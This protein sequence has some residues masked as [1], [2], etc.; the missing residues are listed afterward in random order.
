MKLAILLLAATITF[1]MSAGAVL[2]K[3]TQEQL[4]EKARLVAVKMDQMRQKDDDEYRRL[5]LRFN[6]KAQLIDKNDIDAWC[7][8]YDQMMFEL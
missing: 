2:A 3:C 1:A 7:D 8:F 6:N 5:L 4:E